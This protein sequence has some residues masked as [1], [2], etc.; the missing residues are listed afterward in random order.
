MAT[1]EAE[2]TG[3]VDGGDPISDRTRRKMFALLAKRSTPNTRRRRPARKGMSLV[4]GRE[5]TSASTMSRGRRTSA[6]HA[7][8]KAEL[9]RRE[10]AALA[11]DDLRHERAASR[12]ERQRSGS[13]AK[14]CESC[15]VAPEGAELNITYNLSGMLCDRVHRVVCHRWHGSSRKV[16]STSSRI[17]RPRR[18][19]TSRGGE[20]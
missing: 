12:H 14:A 19:S 2:R 11:Q 8:R 5:I 18:I 13:G 17:L 10:I 7:A 16:G 20:R 6:D 9:T 15:G 3:D 1:V 4:L